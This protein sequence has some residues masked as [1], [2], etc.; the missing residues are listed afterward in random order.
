MKTIK[1]AI[2]LTA[3]FATASSIFGV[4]SIFADGGSIDYRTSA[5][6]S[7]EDRTRVEVTISIPQDEPITEKDLSLGDGS[8]I[9]KFTPKGGG[10]YVVEVKKD[11]DSDRV[12]IK[13][14]RDGS[15]FKAKEEGPVEVKRSQPKTRYHAHAYQS[16]GSSVSTVPSASKKQEAR[17]VFVENKREESA[18]SDLRSKEERVMK[19]SAEMPKTDPQEKLPKEM[20]KTDAKAGIEQNT[21]LRSTAQGMPEGGSSLAKDVAPT[22][23]DVVRPQDAKVKSSTTLTIGESTYK[24]VVE[25]VEM[26]KRM[27]RAPMIHQGRTLLPARMVSEVL[28]VAVNFEDMTKTASFVSED[29]NKVEL[30]FGDRF[31]VVNG[32]KIALSGEM[33]HVEGRILLPLADIQKAFEKLGIQAS[34]TWNAESRSV[35]IDR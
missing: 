19:Q 17:P 13:L 7:A 6:S 26:E 18:A 33:L 8:R 10:V 5:R 14:Q 35:T 23:E 9:E 22:T 25:G 29:G 24:T 16:V 21:P 28:G 1:R 11:E 12:D 31:M 34:L 27:D 4:N 15:N 32:E 2:L 3:A 20:A 30:T